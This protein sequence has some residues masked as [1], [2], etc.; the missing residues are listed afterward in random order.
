MPRKKSVSKKKNNLKDLAE[1]MLVCYDARARIVN[2]IVEDIHKMLDGF[3]KKRHKMSQNL[4]K[5]LAQ[6]ASLR[7]KDFNEMMQE[8][9][10]IHQARE[11]KLKQTLTE[12]RDKEARVVEQLGKLLKKG[13]NI[14]AIHFKKTLK[15][16]QEDQKAIG[17]ADI[18][19]QI[20]QEIG[21]MQ[22]EV[23]KMLETF[24]Q[25]R[26]AAALVWK[27]KKKTL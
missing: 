5:I 11:E 2:E 6:F 17:A 16:I 8:I 1:D 20:R 10:G 26:Q 18:R 21:D 27:K 23:S 3:R 4:Q 13:K 14:R 22:G 24:K 19:T 25:E 7:N 12:F 9:L 15:K